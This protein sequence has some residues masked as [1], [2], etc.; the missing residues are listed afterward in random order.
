MHTSMKGR[1]SKYYVYK[2]IVT[3]GCTILFAENK[4]SLNCDSNYELGYSN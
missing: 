2:D 3:H 1:V 4:M